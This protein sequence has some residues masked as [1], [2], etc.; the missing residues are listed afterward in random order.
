MCGI[1]GIFNF[2]KNNNVSSC[3]I[4][5]MANQIKHRGP[6]QFDLF[7]KE[8]IGF[9]FRRLSIIDIENGNQP[10]YSN[11]KNLIIVFNGE[12]Y[13]Y[14]Y[15]RKRLQSEGYIF[16]TFA[17]TEVILALFEL[18]YK[19]PEQMLDGMFAFAIYDRKKNTLVLSRDI[20]GKKPVFFHETEDGIEFASEQKSLR[21]GVE[22]KINFNIQTISDFLTLGY[23]VQPTTVFSGFKQIPAGHRLTVKNE[24]SF[25][26]WGK[27]PNHRQ[28]KEK[29]KDVV[30]KVE[31]LI[32]QAVE[33]RLMADVP[34]GLFLSSGLDSSLIL[35]MIAGNS[36]PKDFCT[37]TVDFASESFSEG[38]NSKLIAD[39]FGVANQSF[40]MGPE[41]FLAIF[42]ETVKAADNLSANPATFAFSFLAKK[43]VATTK[44][45]LHG[46]GSDEL[47]FGYDTY[48]ANK[49]AE[50]LR[51]FPPGIFKP[52]ASIVDYLP[53]SHKRLGL[54]YKLKKF[55]QNL[56]YEP[57][58]RH[59]QWRTIFT[60]EEKAQ[61]LKSFERQKS[62]FWSYQDA[63]K[64]YEE[65]D[66]H[67]TVSR[68]DFDVWWRS[69]GIY[70]ADITG[71]AHGLETRL[72]FMDNDLRNYLYS[73]PVKSKFSLI[74]RKKILRDIGKYL[75]PQE[76]IDLPKMGF[77]LPL[78]D[79]FRG[80]L[81][82]FVQEKLDSLKISPI[83]INDG[84]YF[85]QILK[86]HCSKKQDNS[87]KLINLV[88]LS[89]WLEINS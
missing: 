33:K 19:F 24:L 75:L 65:C 29:Y 69:M 50:A 85:D 40:C 8:Q 80:P 15:L 62:S 41:D 81:Y 64:N 37:F 71:M 17:D 63:Y 12:I 66:F 88:V 30:V 70:Q 55:F 11:S 27:S 44:V 53:A 78:A 28:K 56:N 76:I 36:L 58:Q 87:F 21:L 25:L 35:S 2:K 39:Y 38:N 84:I 3:Q 61:I 32:R 34:L 10:M 48:Y 72:P 57:L 51:I 20:N 13:N 1:V 45:V 4:K 26:N 73:L 83:V 23:S 22:G 60:E 74:K 43:A 7:I 47:F 9:G 54:D 89:K 49:I 86:E 82:P 5:K 79:W 67:E 68:A 6:D 52:I 42:D 18:G 14:K 59:Y 31:N 16:K 77:H 46:G